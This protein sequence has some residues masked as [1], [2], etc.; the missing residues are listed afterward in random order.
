MKRM[1]RTRRAPLGAILLA[2]ASAAMA[3]AGTSLGAQGRAGGAPQ[4]PKSG[5]PIDL[6]GTWVSVVT[7]DWQW[8]MVTPKKGDYASLP[9]SAEGRKVAD[10]WDP[11][12]DEASGNACKAYGA[13]AI[14]RVP[15]RVRF[16]WLDDQTLRLE[17]DAGTQ[18]RLLRFAGSKPAVGKA[19]AKPDF[20]GE[21]KAEWQYSVGQAIPS[22]SLGAL[23]S[24]A[25]RGAGM[26][27]S[28][29]PRPGGGT[30]KVVT[31]RMKAGYLRKNGVPYSED[32]VLTEY[33]NQHSESDGTDWFTVVT[34]VDDPKYLT[35]QFVTST[36]FRKEANDSKWSPSPCEAR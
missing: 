33:F 28:N 1:E 23:G 34:L 24:G 12:K 20:Q 17:T 32:A 21:S 5:M 10:T 31:T 8:R 16:S 30:L 25:Q 14:M 7:E 15:G 11:A 19:P 27:R 26:G 35:T 36:H 22:V 9:L 29:L 18:T 13:P 3:V 4:T 2:L 6:I